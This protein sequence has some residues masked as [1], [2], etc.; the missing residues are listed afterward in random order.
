ML[1][2]LPEIFFLPSGPRPLLGK[3]TLIYLPVTPSK[4]FTRN[5][6]HWDSRMYK[7]DANVVT[8][9]V[10]IPANVA[11]GIWRLRASTKQQGSRNIKSFDAR[12]KIY[13]L[14]NAW[15]KGKPF[16]TSISP[17]ALFFLI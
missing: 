4:E 3:R 13:V 8:V 6:I 10:Q 17:V 1:F 16:L 9:Q 14:F 15:C 11:V 7:V 12:E 2:F 5:P